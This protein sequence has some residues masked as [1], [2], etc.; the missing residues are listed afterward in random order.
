MKSTTK[1]ISDAEFERQVAEARQR[2]I[3]EP[4]ALS[5]KYKSGV[6]KVDLA[7]GWSFSFDPRRFREF[8]K[9]S[10]KDLSQIGLWGR[11]TIGCEPLNVHLGIGGIIVELL[12][13]QFINSEASR[14]RG[15]AKSEKKSSAS[16]A[17]GKLGG[18]PKRTSKT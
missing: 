9:A 7:S 18:R 10:E 11:F 6:V 1:L 17:N 4:E 12:G 13:D 2:P 15:R 5:A 16:R 3:S 8:E 14:R